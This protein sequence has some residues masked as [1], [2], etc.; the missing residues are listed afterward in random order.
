MLF[1]LRSELKSAG[2]LTFDPPTPADITTQLVE[3]PG[4][5]SRVT[6]H[7]VN[8]P[9]GPAV[10]PFDIILGVSTSEDVTC[11]LGPP[12]RTYYKEDVSLILQ[13]PR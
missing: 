13:L 12:L 9:S 7:F 8:L 5:R 4:G 11:T 6:L 1:N 10:E 3:K 2:E